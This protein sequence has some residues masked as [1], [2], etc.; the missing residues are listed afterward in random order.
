M[1]RLRVAVRLRSPRPLPLAPSP[2]TRSPRPA[3]PAGRAPTPGADPEATTHSSSL[4]GSNRAT[5]I[6]ATITNTHS[7]ATAATTR[8]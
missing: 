5:A 3:G 1:E 6:P 8:R 2:R 4:R 7:R